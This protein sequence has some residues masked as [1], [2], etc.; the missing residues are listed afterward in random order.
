MP[1]RVLHIADEIGPLGIEVRAGPYTGKLGDP[2][3]PSCWLLVQHL[4][5]G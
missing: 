3:Q 4:G 2:N 1:R 5:D